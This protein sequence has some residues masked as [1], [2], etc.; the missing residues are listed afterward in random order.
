MQ[1]Q[2]RAVCELSNSNTYQQFSVTDFLNSLQQPWMFFLSYTHV[3][4]IYKYDLFI[5]NNESITTHI[6]SYLIRLAQLF[7]TL[8]I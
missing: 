5:L 8:E 6:Y 1:K 4:A 7:F 3:E 2:Y